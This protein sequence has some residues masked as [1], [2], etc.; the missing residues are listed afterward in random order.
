MIEWERERK[1]DKEG[2][3]KREKLGEREKE[4]NP[5]IDRDKKKERT[6]SIDT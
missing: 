4:A 3:R 5:L 1:R 2:E 6:F